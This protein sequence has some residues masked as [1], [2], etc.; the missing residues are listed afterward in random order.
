[1]Q[2][3]I[4]ALGCATICTC[5]L[6]GAGVTPESGAD[7]FQ[8]KLQFT[9][10][11]QRLVQG[12]D[13]AKRQAEDYVF[14]GDPVGLWYEAALPGRQAFCMRDTSHQAVG[15]QALGLAAWTHNMLYRFAENIS[16]SK[17]WCSYWEINRFNKPSPADYMSDETFW[18]DLP[19]NFDVVDAAY[20]MYL[21]TGDPSYI[22]DPVFTNFYDRTMNEYVKR[23]QL[24]AGEVMTRER[25][26]LPLNADERLTLLEKE[27]IHRG[28][29][30]YNEGDHT[31]AVGIRLLT[32]EAAAF[33]DYAQIE[34]LRNDVA[35]SQEALKEATALSNLINNT[36]WDAKHDRFY[37]LLNQNHQLEGNS[38]L[39]VLYWNDVEPGPKM[40]GAVKDLLNI[41]QHNPPCYVEAES[42]FAEVLYRY[43][44]PMAAYNTILGLTTPGHCR[45]AYPEVSY[46]VIGAITT[47]LMGVNM[48]PTGALRTLEVQTLPALTTQSSWAELGN[49]PI[50]RNLV[51]VRHNGNRETVFT[52]QNGPAILW[53]AAF[54]GTYSQLLVN[55]KPMPAH[56]EEE[57]LVQISWVEVPV[58]A[59]DTVRVSAPQ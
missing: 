5:L 38:A 18:Y 47:G 40:E 4:M 27:Q 33:R 19:A 43:G 57:S 42:H 25:F 26:P 2:K 54:P 58:G 31:Y 9:S 41:A 52:N 53:R 12:F 48:V 44:E 35:G 49:L 6:L 16:A 15:A 39:P 11:D 28:I 22:H 59:G 56:S 24:G 1:M 29:P 13:W 30:G 50:G 7:P 32:T 17:D 8:S 14:A 51:T 34:Q 55:G 20:R 36:W 37:E 23:W 10:S 46:S 45:Q 3:L 21:W